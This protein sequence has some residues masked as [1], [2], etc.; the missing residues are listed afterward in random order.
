MHFDDL[1]EE[2]DDKISSR[3]S[4]KLNGVV[5]GPGTFFPNGIGPGGFKLKEY[6]GKNLNIEDIEE[7]YEIKGFYQD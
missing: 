5:V 2:I 4:I 7:V 3:V 6:I 1:F